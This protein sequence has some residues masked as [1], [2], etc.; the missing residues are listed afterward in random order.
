MASPAQS[1]EALK[2]EDPYHS[3]LQSKELIHENS[4]TPIRQPLTKRKAF[5]I[6]LILAFIVVVLAAVLLPVFLVTR[7]GKSN[8]QSHAV[9][10]SNG[11]AP[12]F[13][14]GAVSDVPYTI[15]DIEI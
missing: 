11:V 9:D 13:T 3:A 5:W 14:P 4:S 1:Y 2:N 7:K 6:T 10:N 12:T 8:P 15:S